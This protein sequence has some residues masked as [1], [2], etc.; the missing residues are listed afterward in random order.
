MKPTTKIADG[1]VKVL[2]RAGINWKGNNVDD[3]KEA[4]FSPPQNKNKNRVKMKTETAIRI[5]T[6][7]N[8]IC[9]YMVWVTIFSLFKFMFPVFCWC[10]ILM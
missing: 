6:G 8:W 3:R 5:L 7:F 2:M 4:I 9:L 10:A 1:L